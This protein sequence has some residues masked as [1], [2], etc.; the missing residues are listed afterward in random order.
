[1]AYTTEELDLVDG[2]IVT[3]MGR[4]GVAASL[5]EAYGR[6]H[7]HILR[8]DL[9]VSDLQHIRMALNLLLPCFDGDRDSQTRMIRALATTDGLLR[10]VS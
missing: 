2:L 9:D 8:N 6:V 4:R 10:S 3:Y 5:R 7:R 1:M